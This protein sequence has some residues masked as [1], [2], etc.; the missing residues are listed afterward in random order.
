MWL[1]GL[2]RSVFAR[3]R[4]IRVA[5][6]DHV[7]ALVDVDTIGLSYY[8]GPY[9]TGFDCRIPRGSVMRVYDA[10]ELV[11]LCTPEGE[12]E[13]ELVPASHRNDSKYAGAAFQ[14][15]IGDIGRRFELIVSN[16][17]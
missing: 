9:S 13:T 15:D 5:K 16:R 8:N 3:Q 6:G 12:L 1:I 2:V 10:T 11:F 7:R 17:G 4:G 14:F